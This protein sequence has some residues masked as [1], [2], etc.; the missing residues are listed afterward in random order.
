[1]SYTRSGACRIEGCEARIMAL[2]LCS[3]HYQRQYQHPYR[4]V[5]DACPMPPVDHGMCAEH[6][7]PAT[8]RP[9]PKACLEEGCGRTARCLGLCTVH[10]GYL[11]RPNA[12]RRTPWEQRFWR[13]VAKSDECWEWTGASLTSG[14]G[15]FSYCPTRGRKTTDGA[16]R[17]AWVLTN[18]PVPSGLFVCHSCDNKRCCNP[19]HLFLGTPRENVADMVAKG[20]AAWQR[21]SA[22]MEAA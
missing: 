4:C 1:M 7:R 11:R 13:Y 2:G 20:R 8:G 19:A 16:H 3:A 21:R 9:T 17:I 6:F 18:G 10:Y 14:Y 5:V 12:V 22:G 15:K